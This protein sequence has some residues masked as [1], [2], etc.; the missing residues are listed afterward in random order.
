MYNFV[1]KYFAQIVHF[2]IDNNTTHDLYVNHN[3]KFLLCRLGSEA[4]DFWD[5]I[6]SN[7]LENLKAKIKVAKLRVSKQCCCRHLKEYH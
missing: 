6:D 4:M 7:D 3:G 1:Q 5:E 2:C